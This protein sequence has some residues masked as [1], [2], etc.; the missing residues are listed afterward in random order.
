MFARKVAVSLKATPAR[1]HGIFTSSSM[2]LAMNLT[3]ALAS[4]PGRSSI[5]PQ[6]LNRFPPPAAPIDPPPT[7]PSASTSS[8]WPSATPTLPFAILLME[9]LLVTIFLFMIF[10][11]MPQLVF[12]MRHS[13]SSSRGKPNKLK[14]F[15][16]ELLLGLV[17]LLLGPLINRGTL[18]A[19][20]SKSFHFFVHKDAKLTVE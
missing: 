4:T 20:D 6:L 8:P 14:T 2:V 15:V 7:S 9:N 12:T 3:E 16:V 17:L 18:D 19:V 1:L 13:L 5:K 11:W 10:Y